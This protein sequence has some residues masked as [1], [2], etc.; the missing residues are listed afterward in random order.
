MA[1]ELTIERVTAP[2]T[3]LWGSRRVDMDMGAVEG[4]RAVLLP[5]RL[6]SRPRLLTLAAPRPAL[7]LDTRA[8]AAWACT[9]S[10]RTAPLRLTTTGHVGVSYTVVGADREKWLIMQISKAE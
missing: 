10:N 8:P 6:T 7:E 3:G 4:T 1:R 9:H 5:P 2:L